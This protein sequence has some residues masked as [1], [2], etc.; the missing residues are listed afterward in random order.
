MKKILAPINFSDVSEN[1]MNYAVEMAKLTQ[2]ELIL[3]HVYYHPAGSDES[4]LDLP[5]SKEMEEEYMTSLRRERSKIQSEYGSDLKIKCYCRQGFA[6]DEINGFA[7]EEQVDLIVMGMR[8][9][10]FLTEKIIG[11][12]TTSLLRNAPCPAMAIDSDVTFRSIKRIVFASDFQ[13]TSPEVLKPLKTFVHLFHARLYVLN[14]IDEPEF[15]PQVTEAVHAFSIDREL[16]ELDHSF[17]DIDN[18]DVVEGINDFVHKNKMD[19]VVMIP[20]KHSLFTNIFRESRTKKL[21]FHASVPLLALHEIKHKQT[22]P[23]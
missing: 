17:H 6:I 7:K 13:E 15:V 1:S 2:S 16:A 21:A 10:G 8:S 14:V 19:M 20:R 23:S 22:K 9:A 3:L 12:V 4:L 18:D 11:S 5:S